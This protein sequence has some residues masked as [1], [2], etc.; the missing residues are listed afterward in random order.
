MISV[1][2]SS[3]RAREIIDKVE[4]VFDSMGYPGS[5]LPREGI[6]LSLIYVGPGQPLFFVGFLYRFV[7]HGSYPRQWR[8][9]LARFSKHVQWN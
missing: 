6:F 1:A 3:E 4:R 8:Q 2:S 9:K 7:C 5:Q